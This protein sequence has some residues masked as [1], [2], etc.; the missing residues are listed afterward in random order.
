[1]AGLAEFSMLVSKY[2]ILPAYIWLENLNPGKV[3]WIKPIIINEK[4]LQIESTCSLYE[5]F[6][7]T[8]KNFSDN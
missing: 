4:H 6:L 2:C 7:K 8:S 3:V 5:N 1:M